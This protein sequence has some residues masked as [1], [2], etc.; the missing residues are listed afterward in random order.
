MPE[1]LDLCAAFAELLDYPGPEFAVRLDGALARLAVLDGAVG[2]PLGQFQNAVRAATVAE[3]EE[4]YTR[5]FDMRPD[6]APYAGHQLFGED[7]RRSLFMVRLK[8]HYRERGFSAGPDLPDHL[9]VMLRF[10]AANP[11]EPE[12]AE[13][14][15]ECVA[16][17]V[18][19]IGCAL[20]AGGP[21]GALIQ[22]LSAF[23]HSEGGRP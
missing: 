20:G 19:K 5:T 21:Y 15:S 6:C 16:P 23:L 11:A 17:A 13:L 3:L 22:A 12:S 14:I 4:A 7:C 9:P 2:G 10:V 1:R 18:G 8:Q